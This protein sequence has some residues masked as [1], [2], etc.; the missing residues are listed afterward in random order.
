MS[1]PAGNPL[2]EA[3][4]AI[5]GLGLMGG[6][7][8]YDLAGKCAALVGVDPDLETQNLARASGCF[9]AVYA[10]P[11]E[12]YSS[13]DVWILA[14]PVRAILTIL[15]ELPGWDSRS[16]IVLDIGSTKTQILAAMEELPVRF[17]PLG[18]HPMCGKETGSYAS[19]GPGLFQGAA[20]AWCRLERTSPEAIQLATALTAAIGGIPRWLSAADHDRWTAATSHL[21]YLIA[22]ALA[23]TTPGDAAPLIGP[24]FQSTTRIAGSPPE[25]MLDVLLTNRQQI[26]AAAARFQA[27]FQGFIDLL[28][29]GEKAEI[30]Q[31]SAHLQ[32]GRKSRQHLLD[33]VNKP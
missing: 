30:E 32:A 2:S 1:D 22:S 23:G 24:G 28:Q 33:S 12:I 3:R 29:S 27:G 25:M 10:R 16:G 15:A 6:S 8:A 19:A 13:V 14:A 20:F 5:L 31:L 26:L 7:L 18:G 17:D 21:P 4:I 9:Q 11:T